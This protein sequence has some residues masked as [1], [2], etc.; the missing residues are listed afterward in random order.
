VIPVPSL[1][2]LA[3]FSGRPETSY[4]SYATSA[5]IQATIIFTT[6]TE[7]NYGNNSDFA[8]LNSDDQQ[9]AVYGILAYADWTYLKQPYQQM[10]ASP[11]MSETIGDY[12][13][14]KPPP[15]QVRN[16]QAQELGIGSTGVELWDTA[17]QY[18][19]KRTRAGGVFF[20][21]LRCFD[22]SGDSAD[23]DIGIMLREDRRTGEM[24]L[25]GPG[26]FNKVDIP[27]FGPDV[28]AE[29]FPGDPGTG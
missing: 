11:A 9:L 14:S 16:V 22:R 13:F 27:G 5:L 4:T 1:A 24:V 15:I 20:G 7:V 3:E 19:S 10:V 26:D 2:Q 21:Q 12:T 23:R 17:V 8:A 18:L 25:L 6:V 29:S 28:N